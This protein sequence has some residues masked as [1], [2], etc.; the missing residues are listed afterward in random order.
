MP[1]TRDC[2]D[3]LWRPSRITCVVAAGSG[4]IVNVE[5]ETDMAGAIH[6]KGF[7][8]LR[9]FLASRFGQT[10]AMSMHAS[11]TFEQLYG[12]IDGDSA[13][14]T[15]I[16]AVL[17]AL[18]DVPISQHIAVTGSV[19][20]HGEI[21]PIGGGTHKIEGFYEVCRARGLDGSHGVTDH[22]CYF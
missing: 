8:I 16:Y 6:N 17:S 4:T 9:G 18:A 1:S 2:R 13:S 20:Q 21:Q 11:M 22:W 14:S 3:F 7:M 15:E 5:R 19:N 12:G 10:R